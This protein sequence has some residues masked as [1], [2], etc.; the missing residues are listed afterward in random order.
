MESILLT[1]ETIRGFE[2]DIQAKMEDFMIAEKE[3]VEK[4]AHWEVG[5]IK[6]QAKRD[7]AH[8]HSHAFASRFTPSSLQNGYTSDYLHTKATMLEDELS[9]L[10]PNK[11]SIDAF[12][13]KKVEYEERIIELRNVSEARDCVRAQYETLRKRRLEEFMTVRFPL[14]P[15]MCLSSSRDVSS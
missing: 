10:K 4:V 9:I 12:E 1:I 6:L 8:L 2:V 13:N 11:S 7:A 15:N 3:S 14:E 5:L